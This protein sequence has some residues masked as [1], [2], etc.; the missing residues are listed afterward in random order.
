MRPDFADATTIWGRFGKTYRCATCVVILLPCI[1]AV[2]GGAGSLS[3]ATEIA[4]LNGPGTMAW[5][6]AVISEIVMAGTGTARMPRSRFWRRGLALHPRFFLRRAQNNLANSLQD[7]TPV[8]QAIESDQ[9]APPSGAS[10]DSAVPQ[11]TSGET[12]ARL[13]ARLEEGIDPS[14]RASKSIPTN[15]KPISNSRH[16]PSRTSAGPGGRGHRVAPCGRAIA[17]AQTGRAGEIQFCRGPASIGPGFLRAWARGH[18]GR[19]TADECGYLCPEISPRTHWD[20]KRS[21]WPDLAYPY[22]AGCGDCDFSSYAY[23][24]Q[25]RGGRRGNLE[26]IHPAICN[27]SFRRLLPGLWRNPT[28]HPARRRASAFSTWHGPY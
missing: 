8:C 9:H 4:R 23:L 6:R 11:T 5:P 19:R 18:E 12:L 27:P 13:P 7:T 2:N 25:G 15:A 26:K 10:P 14:R 1:T 17:L 22:R 24:Q 16:R 21:Q 20:G 28:A 3:R